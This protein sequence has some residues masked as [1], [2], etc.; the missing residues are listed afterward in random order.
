MVVV[1][2]RANIRRVAAFGNFVASVA[3]LRAWVAGGCLVP[4]AAFAFAAFTITGMKTRRFGVFAC[5]KFT[6]LATTSITLGGVT[7]LPR[8]IF[9][10]V[11]IAAFT[12]AVISAEAYAGA[13]IL[14][15]LN[16]PVGAFAATCAMIVPAEFVISG[17]FSFSC[18]AAKA[19]AVVWVGVVEVG[20]ISPFI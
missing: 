15:M 18:A 3:D 20:G 6:A 17:D 8:F 11:I 7:L 16:K 4:G 10:A 1:C 2:C 5:G 13:K 19:A 9:V 14:R 12:F